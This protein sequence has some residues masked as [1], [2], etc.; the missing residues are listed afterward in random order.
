MTASNGRLGALARR[1][2]GV[3]PDAITSRVLGRYGWKQSDLTVAVAPSA[4]VRLFVAPANSAGQGWAWARAVERELA[5]VG[6]FDMMVRTP[7]SDAFGFSA[8]Q[9]IP[10]GAFVFASGWRKRQRAALMDGFTHVLLE[11]GQFPYGSVPGKTPRDAA[12][13]LSAAGLEVALLWHGSDIRMPSAHAA[14]EQDSP[15]RDGGAYPAQKTAVLE[16]NARKNL[17]F[18]E[19]T[20]FPVFVSTPDLLPYAPRSVWLPGVVDVERWAAAAT[21]SPMQRTTPVVV[22]APSNAGLKGT[23]AI[24]PIMR[25]LHD[26]GVVEYRELSGIPSAQMPAAYGAADIVLDQFSLGIYGVAANEALAAGR[27]VVSHV[28]DFTRRT[29]KEQTGLDLPIVE[30]RADALERVVRDIVA[31]RRAHAELAASGPA[32][33][34]AVHDGRRSARVLADFLGVAPMAEAPA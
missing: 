24:R 13:T 29:V 21:S 1:A 15:F 20:D 3:V 4:S 14:A 34:R 12:A 9:R 30:T 33:V 25:R 8:D 16:R 28:G 10:D 23:E 17:G 19:S 27:I 22:H 32:F 31:D 5:H 26:E 18:I 2:L 7:G 11:S 6:A